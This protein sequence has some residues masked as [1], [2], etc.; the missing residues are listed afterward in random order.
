MHKK[1]RIRVS[2]ISLHL[3]F[4]IVAVVCIYPVMLI[5]FNAITS[6]TYINEIG[7]VVFPKEATLDAFKYLF[8][9]PKRLLQSTYAT[10][11]YAIGG[12][13]FSVVIQAMLGY[14]LTRKDFILRKPINVL[15]TITM[16]FS[17]GLIPTYMVNT[18]IYHL[19]NSWLMYIFDGSVSAFNVFV[20]RTFFEQIPGSLIESAE[21]DGATHMQILTK[22]IVPLSKPILATQFFLTL[23][24][25]WK[26]YTVSLY[27]MTDQSKI[28]LG[29]YTQM[30]LDSANQLKENAIAMG[31]SAE[32]VP[33]E[34]MRFA[35]VF[36]TVIPLVLIFPF[37]QKHFQKGATV[38]AVKG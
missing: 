38:G 16:F 33:I 13:I 36:F 18:T 7:Y 32:D 25:R 24:Q 10:I 37:M 17:A 2:T 1:K 28:N 30:L 12:G 9:A 19:D 34:S 20:F 5:L 11:I 29:H 15:L 31:L 4:M 8:M 14:T 21:V 26:T 22:I 35:V 3:F 6:E 23:V 27:Y